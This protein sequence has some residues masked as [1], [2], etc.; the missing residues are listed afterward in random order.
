MSSHG[1][2]RVVSASSISSLLL[3]QRRDRSDGPS[4]EEEMSGSVELDIME[5]DMVSQEG[6]G[7]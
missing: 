1:Y 3:K 4:V 2:S 5:M 7:G 6:G